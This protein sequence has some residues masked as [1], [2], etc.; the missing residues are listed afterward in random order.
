M[1]T[2]QVQSDASKSKVAKLSYQ[3][4]GPFEIVSHLGNGAYEL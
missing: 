2:V 1:A 4:R 3:H